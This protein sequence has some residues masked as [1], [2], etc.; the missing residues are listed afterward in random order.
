MRKRIAIIGA[1]ASGLM[2]AWHS[3]VYGDVVL[4]EKQK[5]IGRKLLITGNGRCNISNRFIESSRYHGDNPSFVN[6][7]FGAYSQEDT[8]N[9]FLSI[10]IP[11]TEEKEGRLYPSCLQASILPSVF[12]YELKNKNIDLQLHRRVDS[13]VK[14]G[15]DFILTTAGQEVDHFDSVILACGSPA[16]PQLGGST[17]GYELAKQLGHSLIKPVPCILPIN[18]PAK[19]LHTLQGIKWDVTLSVIVDNQK[20]TSSTG[21]MLFT[22]YGISGPVALDISRVVNQE[23]LKRN[24]PLI[25]ID[26]FPQLKSQQLKDLCLILWQEESKKISFSL[27]GILKDR[28]PEVILSMMKIDSKKRI[29]ELTQNEKDKILKNLKSFKV[30]P[31][32]PRTFNEAV[33]AAGGIPVSEIDSLTMESTIMPGLFITGEMLDIDGDS[34]GFNLQFAWSTGALAGLS[35]KSKA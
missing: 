2:A 19:P 28:M 1:G 31:G 10:G 9:F 35:Q 33:V 12:S 6:N 27:M 22:A 8:E 14:K 20:L 30:E 26:F 29:S 5:K 34:G 18:L 21:E 25:E 23:L 7:I 17:G 32:I 16:Y 3:A 11:F 15:N 24:K 4:Y 13:I